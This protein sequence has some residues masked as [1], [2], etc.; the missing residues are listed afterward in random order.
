MILRTR[1]YA[2]G[3]DQRVDRVFSE[4]TRSLAAPRTPA[5]DA[6]WV[7][8]SLRLTLDLPGT[9]D[10]AI[11][12]DVAGRTLTVSVDHEGHAWRRDVRLGGHL[13][14]SQV[15]ADYAHG[16]LT[17]TVAPMPEPEAR[18]ITLGTTPPAAVETS[19]TDAALDTDTDTESGTDT[20]SDSA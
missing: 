19:A 18:R 3:F 5:I 9:P 6:T 4:L 20:E 2:P 16:R 12:V 15:V 7:D 10:E 14:P 13:D 8:G 11:A 1:P 17:I